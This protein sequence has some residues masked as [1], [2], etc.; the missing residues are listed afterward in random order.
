MTTTEAAA[1][2]EDQF[3]AQQKKTS[4]ALQQQQQQQLSQSDGTVADTATPERDFL[5]HQQGVF[6]DMAAVFATGETV[7]PEL[8]PV[9]EHLARSILQAILTSRTDALRK[10]QARNITGTAASAENTISQPIQKLRLLDVAAGT[11][12][13]WDYYLQAA[14]AANIS[15]EIVGV[16]LSAAMVRA[17]KAHA[18]VVLQQHNT[19]QDRTPLHHDIQVVQAD[20]LQFTQNSDTDMELFD[21]VVMNACFGNFWNPTAVL[22]HVQRQWLRESGSLFVSHP[23]GS[24]F[25]AKLHRNDPTTVPHLLPTREQL[26]NTTLCLP[27]VVTEFAEHAILPTK[28][29]SSDGGVDNGTTTRNQTVPLY[30]AAAT[31]VRESFL[32]VM[33]RLRGPVDAGYG[34]GG[35]NLGF[36]TANLPSR[37]FQDSL[38]TVATGV[39]FGWAV[40]ENDNDTVSKKKGRDVYHKAVVNV[41]YSPTFQGQENVEKIVEA[42]L[43]GN[44]GMDPPDFYNE[45]MRLQLH[46]FMRPEIKF[47]S[48]PAL[49]AQ[50]KTDVFDADEALDQETN[51]L[52]QSDSFLATAVGAEM[53][54]P[55]P[56]VGTDGGDATASWEFQDIRQVL[57]QL[58]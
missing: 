45:T 43:I 39:Y 15:L 46:G 47:P 52:L 48:F 41:G 6:D 30:F 58:R 26:Y 44:T 20:I 25:V 34:R 2:D 42:H 19:A 4:Q 27:L 29:T 21:G 36:P 57:E 40:I 24:N 17:A 55:E 12:A 18:A 32:P 9:L 7:T 50:I 38:Q 54:H 11:G 23:L 13:L 33:V 51:M 16:D 53:V 1:F 28:G 3:A 49:I 35:K 22:D 37:L 56:W 14:A 10:A 5:R 8:V 31:K